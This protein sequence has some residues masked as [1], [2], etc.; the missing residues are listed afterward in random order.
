MKQQQWT[1]NLPVQSWV[2]FL[3]IDLFCSGKVS[4]LIQS[5]YESMIYLA[6]SLWFY[7]NKNL[8][9]LVNLITVYRY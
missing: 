5:I 2:Y 3:K 6:S 4:L 8:T 1:N 7:S 9:S